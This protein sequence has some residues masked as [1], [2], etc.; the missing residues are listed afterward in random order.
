MMTIGWAA[1]ISRISYWKQIAADHDKAKALPWHLPRVGA[2]PES[3]ALAEKAVGA[4][5]S[6]EFKEFLGYANGW[7]GFHLLTDLFGTKEFLEG[8]SQSVLRR[9]ELAAFL[10]ANDLHEVDVFSIGSSDLDLDV[11][12][13]FSPNSKI[14]PKGVLWF[15]NEEVDRYASFPEFFSAMVNYNARIAQKM[16][17]CA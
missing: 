15:A 16:M 11:F 7:Q 3:I 1:E 8:K 17:D 4:S 12:L 9:P 10:E 13:H 14:L 6:I 2:K 5:F